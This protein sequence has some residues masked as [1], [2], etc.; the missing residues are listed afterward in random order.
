MTRPV[1]QAAIDLIKQVEGLRLTA[2]QDVAGV[3]TIGYGSTK[4]VTNGDVITQAQAEAMLA[5]DL[6]TAAERLAGV[7]DE[8]VI[9]LLTDNQ[10]AALLSFVFNLGANPSW[11]IWKVLNARQFDQVPAQLIR[12]VYAGQPPVKVQGLVN[13]RTLEINVW[14]LD[15][16]GS[17][18]TSPPSSVT[19]ATATP[20]VPIDPKPRGLAVIASTAIATTAAAIPQAQ[21]AL[22]AVSDAVTPYRDS[23]AII[24]HV[25]SLVGVAGAGLAVSALVLKYLHDRSVKGW[26]KSTAPALH[27]TSF[28]SESQVNPS[29]P[30]TV[31]QL[32]GGQSVQVPAPGATLAA[33]VAPAAPAVASGAGST[34][35][36]DLADL[37]DSIARCL[38][39]L[40]GEAQSFAGKTV[41]E[42]IAEAKKLAAS[43]ESKL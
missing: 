22:Q 6:G 43:V 36:A 37:R 16:P 27:P 33:P 1:P 7:V 41:S 12:F 11:T 32:I 26:S 30:Q 29:P 10:Y 35:T 13:R 28:A 24:G 20:A 8:A 39:K 23:A 15:E 3:W 40:S 31:G 42:I 38:A 5:D 25:L 2:Y 21:G 18:D 14:S 17:I 34:I 4:R 9:L 19:R